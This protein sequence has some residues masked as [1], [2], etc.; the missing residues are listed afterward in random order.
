[1]DND[2]CDNHFELYS[3]RHSSRDV[4]SANVITDVT[5]KR[6]SLSTMESSNPISIISGNRSVGPKSTLKKSK[7]ERKKSATGS[8]LTDKSDSSSKVN[9]L[10]SRNALTS[11]FLRRKQIEYAGTDTF[12]NEI[13]VKKK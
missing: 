12:L 5:N 11:S 2:N 3:R 7:S 1:M 6:F 8:D 10:K 4:P 9:R 13:L